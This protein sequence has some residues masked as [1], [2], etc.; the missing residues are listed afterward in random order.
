MVM[1]SLRATPVRVT[2]RGKLDRHGNELAVPDAALGDHMVG[3]FANISCLPSQYRDLH[4]ALVIE[5][6]V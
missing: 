6:D 4:A 5:M 1:A 3:E 2:F